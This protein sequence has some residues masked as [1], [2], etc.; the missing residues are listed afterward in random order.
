MQ[1]EDQPFLVLYHLR[2][3]E[4]SGL[5]AMRQ[6]RE[7]YSALIFEVGTRA[8]YRAGNR[9]TVGTGCRIV[10]AG[11]DAL[12]DRT[13]YEVFQAA[14]LFMYLVPLHPQHIGQESLCEPVPTQHCF[15]RLISGI[16]ERYLALVIHLNIPVSHE[17]FEHF[18]Y[19][20]R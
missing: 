16:C 10:Q 17:A 13:R 20:W 3:Q 4:N 6:C 1:V 18:S 14:G 5:L 11:Y 8:G 2:D 7:S 12:L 9:V 19:R 15:S